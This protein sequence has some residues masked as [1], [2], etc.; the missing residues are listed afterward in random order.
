MKKYIFLITSIFGLINLVACGNLAGSQVSNQTNGNLQS[1][2]NSNVFTA[3]GTQGSKSLLSTDYE[4]ALSV[5]MQLIIGSFKLEGTQNAID[6]ATAKNLLPLWQAVKALGS[7]DTTSA[8]EMEALYKQIEETMTPEQIEAISAMRL[9]RE[10]MVQVTQQMGLSYSAS[11]RFGNLTPEQQATAQAARQSGQGF[12]PG[13]IPGG[14]PFGGGQGG[15]FN[16]QQ[17]STAF[18]R[19]TGAP[20]VNTVFVDAIIKFLQA[21]VQ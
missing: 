5:T 4:N 1:T 14:E 15:G 2:S 11:G 17:Q 8:V 19:P 21:K 6:A 20:I 10:D 16:P 9:T 12:P 13:G 3:G 7:S 18:A